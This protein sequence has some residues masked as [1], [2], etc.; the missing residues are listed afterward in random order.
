MILFITLHHRYKNIYRNVYYPHFIAELK[1]M[2]AIFKLVTSIGTGP[3]IICALRVA[4]NHKFPISSYWLLMSP[5]ALATFKKQEP[6][7]VSSGGTL[8]NIIP[9]TMPASL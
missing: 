5:L 2:H 9:F 7:L 8:I 6:L 3:P 4:V 1:A